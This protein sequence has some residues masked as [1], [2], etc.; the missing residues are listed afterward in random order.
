MKYLIKK[1]IFLFTFLSLFLSEIL[2]AQE[3]FRYYPK[4]GSLNPGDTLYVIE[5][6]A[7]NDGELILISTMMGILAQSKP[8]IWIN[9]GS[10]YPQWLSELENQN[11]LIINN[12]YNYDVWGLF[13]LLKNRLENHQYILCNTNDNSLNVATSLAGIWKTV[14]IDSTIENQMREMD[15]TLKSDVCGKDEKWCFDNY[16]GEFNHSL[17]IQQKEELTSLRD[18]ASLSNSIMFY[19]GNSTFMEQVLDSADMDAAM[20]GWGDASQGEDKFIKPASK[21]SVFTVPSDHAWN[22]SVLSAI[23]TDTLEQHTHTE[24]RDTLGLVHTVTFIMSDGDNIQWLMN[25]FSTSEKWYGSPLR[26]QFNM[27]WTISPSMVDLAPTI[28][29]YLYDNAEK[30]YFVSGVSGGGYFYPADYP[31]LET[32]GNRLNDYLKRTDINIV[33]ILEHERD[34]FTTEILNAYTRNP[35]IIGCFYLDYA[36]YDYYAG[37][38]VWSNGKPVVSARFNLWDSFDTPQSIANLVNVMSKNPTGIQAYSFIN[39]HPWSRTLTDV[40]ETIS[41]FGDNV[42]VVTPELFIKRMNDN[43]P[44]DETP[45]EEMLPLKKVKKAKIKIYPNPAGQNSLSK[46]SVLKININ[47]TPR[48]VKIIN[49]LGQTVSEWLYPSPAIIWNGKNQNG[50]S[51]PSGIYFVRINLGE[52]IEMRKFIVLK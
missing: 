36:Q 46:D 40:Q 19:D 25:D 41:L 4:G 9:I 7:M 24:D 10:A 38:V 2:S 42:E 11:G 45:I 13:N 29:A 8:K 3:G 17:I 20:L 50:I 14:A 12:D 52:K 35:Q 28:M 6:G 23:E 33:T 48:S 44:H 16:W 18:Y 47:S 34:N 1:N 26:G 5:I 51:V 30:D 31:A 27:G 21:A 39:V 49:T 15:F 37:K 22:L 43:V 32:H